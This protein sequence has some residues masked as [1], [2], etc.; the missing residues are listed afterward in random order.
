MFGLGLRLAGS[1]TRERERQ[2][3]EALLTIPEFRRDVLQAKWVGAW[4][5]T[6]VYGA[7]LVLALLLCALTGTSGVSPCFFALMVVLVHATFA[8]NLGLYLSLVCRTTAR[9]SISFALIFLFLIAGSWAAL[10]L[11]P[12]DDKVEMVVLNDTLGPM[13]ATF[14]DDSQLRA[15]V[16]ALNPLLT[17]WHLLDRDPSNQIQSESEF[18]QR[19]ESRAGHRHSADYYRRQFQEGMALL[20]GTMIYLAAAGI[21]WLLAD[22][23][24]RRQAEHGL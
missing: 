7:G 13:Q 24:F 3:L 17:W 16:R 1:V 2:T 9:A 5:R 8:A 6:R 10:E 18:E 15:G 23:R 21:L 22:R 11:L 20:W 4:L 19:R 14:D 12:G